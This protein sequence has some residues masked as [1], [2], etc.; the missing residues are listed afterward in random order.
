MIDNQSSMNVTNAGFPDLGFI[1]AE[2]FKELA[3]INDAEE[4]NSPSVTDNANINGYDDISLS[5]QLT[6]SIKHELP[7][8]V[9]SKEDEMTPQSIQNGMLTPISPS[10]KRPGHRSQNSISTPFGEMD[11]NTMINLRAKHRRTNSLMKRSS[12]EFSMKNYGELVWTKLAVLSGRGDTLTQRQFDIELQNNEI[13][14]DPDMGKE[15]FLTIQSD[16]PVNK[17]QINKSMLFS[18]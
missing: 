9:E 13:L 18:I 5:R 2:Q 14:A 12:S 10:F 7:A 16:E 1:S 6:P 4:K 3:M 15:L 8:I 17:K 11:T